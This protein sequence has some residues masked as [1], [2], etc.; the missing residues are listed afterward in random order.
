MDVR[1]RCARRVETGVSGRAAARRLMLSASTGTRLARQVRAGGDLAPATRG[2]PEG[3]GKLGP[4]QDVLREMVEADADITMPELARA[5]E[6]AT[7][8]RA[9]PASLSRALRRWGVRVRK[10]P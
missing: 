7:G 1:R 8:V 4:H 2:R 10:S 6:E 5:L 3:A 9:A